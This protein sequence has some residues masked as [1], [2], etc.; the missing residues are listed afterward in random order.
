[1][2][3][4]DVV[5]FEVRR[6]FTIWHREPDGHDSGEVC[7]HYDRATGRVLNGWR[8]HVRHWRVQVLPWQRVRTWLVDRCDH[9]GYRFHWREARFGY[10]ST[11]RLWHDPCMSLRHVRGQLDDLTRK[12]LG[13]ADWDANWRAEHRLSGIE[14][15][16]AEVR[17]R[18]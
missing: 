1:M 17:D 11:D 16:T 6:L 10:Q 8:W 18:G 2:H 12:V 15:Q 9:C 14:A 5:A 7:Q 4:P 13:T 3:D